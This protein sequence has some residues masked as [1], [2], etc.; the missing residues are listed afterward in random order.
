MDVDV[1]QPSVMT[2]ALAIAESEGIPITQAHLR[3]ATVV[4]EAVVCPEEGC[5]MLRGHDNDCLPTLVRL[6]NDRRELAEALDSLLSAH[7]DG[8]LSDYCRDILQEH[9]SE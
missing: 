2:A 7:P 6:A 8:P 9:G 3:E 4:V 5:S 1:P